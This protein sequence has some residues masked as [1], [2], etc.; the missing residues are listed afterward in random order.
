[1][2][3]I[4]S[5]TGTAP[6]DLPGDFRFLE[7]FGLKKKKNSVALLYVKRKKNLKSYGKQMGHS[8]FAEVLT[9]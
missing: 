7:E 8:L 9:T 5:N 2:P 4:V 6:L 1:M 3:V